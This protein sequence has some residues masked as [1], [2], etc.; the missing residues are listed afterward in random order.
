MTAGDGAGRIRFDAGVL[1]G[2]ACGSGL[3]E[4]IGVAADVGSAT[5]SVTAGAE[6]NGIAVM[7]GLGLS[8]V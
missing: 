1:G 6:F 2:T 3:V 5:E 8:S 4:V 7:L